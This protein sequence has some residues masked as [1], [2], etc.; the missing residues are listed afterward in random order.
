MSA[1]GR[2]DATVIHEV[3]EEFSGLTRQRL[4]GYLPD[5]EPRRYLYE[6]LRD[7]PDRGGRG[8]R[9]SLC[10]AMA[11][12]LGGGYGETTLAAAVSIE[13]CHNA[14]LI[15]DDIQ[16]DSE[17]R[18]GQSTLH[19]RIGTPL[20]LNAGD[21]LLLM[22]VRPLLDHAAQLGPQLSLQLVDEMERMCIES[23]E[24]QALD[25]G[26]RRDNVLDIEAPDYLEMVLKKTCYLS[27]ILPLRV[28]ARLGARGPVD[29]DAL[30]RLGFFM[31]AAFQIRDDM[32]N[33]VGDPVRY[34]KELHGDI[35]EGKRTLMLI[36]LLQA[37][38]KKD[39]P[40]YQRLTTLLGRSRAQRDNPGL[41]AWVRGLMDEAGS[42]EHAHQI[43]LG[44]AGAAQHEWARL[45]AA[46]PDSREK[47]FIDALTTWV[48]ERE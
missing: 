36:H 14:A 3:L 39:P 27:T 44:L 34:G 5:K 11:R 7:Y 16:D 48:V 10:I 42:I 41:V 25:I 12:A 17:L 1:R 32:L 22:S 46:L 40:T 13:L 15:H 6:P 21:A 35:L 2:Y 4:R 47:R 8:L 26:W 28:G 33:L 24:G 18:R 29:L 38:A 31:G 23:A 45:S 37:T 43:A 9:P 19:Q 30:T 20:A